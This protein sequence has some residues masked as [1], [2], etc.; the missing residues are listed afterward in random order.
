MSYFYPLDT[1]GEW[2][3][4]DAGRCSGVVDQDVEAAQTRYRLVHHAGRTLGIGNVAC[5]RDDTVPYRYQPLGG[6]GPAWV[7]GQMVECHI[8][9]GRRQ[10]LDDGKTDAGCATRDQSLFAL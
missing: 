9:T 4:L 6:A 3:R 5:Y 2:N 8:G 1:I 7:I 10:Q